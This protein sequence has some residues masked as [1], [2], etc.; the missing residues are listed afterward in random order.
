M[1]RS[2]KEQDIKSIVGQAFQP[3]MEPGKSGSGTMYSWP[4]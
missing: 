2:E 3:D 4:A 1:K